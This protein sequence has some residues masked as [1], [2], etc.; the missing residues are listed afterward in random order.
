MRGR[1]LLAGTV[2]VH[3]QRGL[4]QR[5]PPQT[6]AAA[7]TG[8]VAVGG[9]GLGNTRSGAPRTC[10]V[11]ARRAMPL[12]QAAPAVRTVQRDRVRGTGSNGTAHDLLSLRG[13]Q[14][15]RHAL[16]GRDARFPWRRASVAGYLPAD[17]TRGPAQGCAQPAAPSSC[18]SASC[19]RFPSSALLAL[20]L[21]PP[22]S[23][24]RLYPQL[25]AGA[26]AQSRNYAIARKLIVDVSAQ[27]FVNNSGWW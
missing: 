21:R 14:G 15:R 27:D 1:L 10:R 2:S 9:F 6:R 25:A 12:L 18:A 16:A 22:P 23:R 11:A 7:T 20:T 17:P 8:G 24:V 5:V 19:R 3:M 26:L 13:N 4:R